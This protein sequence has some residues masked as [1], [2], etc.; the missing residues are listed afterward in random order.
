MDYKITMGVRYGETEWLNTL[1]RLIREK[2]DEIE[3]ILSSY[4][5]P[6]LDARGRL[7][8][9][10]PWLAAPE[11]RG[12]LFDAA[13]YRIADYRAPVPHAPEGVSAVETARVAE[14]LAAGAIA[15]DVFPAPRRPENRPQG[16]LWIAPTRATL[17]DAVWLPNIGLGLL[18][19]ET[20][21]YFAAALEA[22]TGGDRLRPIIFFCERDCWMSW[23]A[24]RR[25][26]R[27]LGW[28]QVYWYP[29]GTDGWREA[30]RPLVEREPLEVAP[31]TH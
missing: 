17:P 18:P 5:V 13:G 12:E 10:P 11:Q 7:I 29:D 28:Q 21:S 25:A 1:N 24:A 16:A 8:N 27:E 9:P 14:L 6:L 20:A 26:K 19:P 4:H 15:V 23:N 30:G 3:A 2:R 22:V 31:R